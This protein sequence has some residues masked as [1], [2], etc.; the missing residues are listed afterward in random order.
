[1]LLECGHVV[2]RGR[3]AHPALS[4]GVQEGLRKAVLEPGRDVNK[5]LSSREE[6]GDSGGWERACDKIG[7][8]RHLKRRIAMSGLWTGRAFRWWDPAAHCRKESMLGIIMYNTL[9][10]VEAVTGQLG[11]WRAYAKKE[12]LE[13]Q[14]RSWARFQENCSSGRRKSED[15]GEQSIWGT[16]RNFDLLVIIDTCE[17]WC[18]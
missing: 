7:K 6:D 18:P 17:E 14:E 5:V 4:R 1:M 15:M 11:N 12:Q 3:G 10:V 8:N 13:E 2:R 16:G 9:M